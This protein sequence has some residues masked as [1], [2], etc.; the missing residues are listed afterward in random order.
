MSPGAIKAP[1]SAAA[2]EAES[3]WE[4]QTDFQGRIINKFK[5]A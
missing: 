4:R 1:I 5:K 3:N 2:T